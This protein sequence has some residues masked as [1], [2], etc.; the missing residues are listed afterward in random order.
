MRPD[1]AKLFT[2]NLWLKVISIFIAVVLWS[3][4]SSRE[5]ELEVP[6][7]V[8][9]EIKNLSK[10]LVR[11]SD[12]PNEIEIKARGPRTVLRSLRNREMRYVLDLSGAM[13][14]PMV[15]K[16][17]DSKIEG[18]PKGASVSEIYPSQIQLTLS[19]R[20]SRTVR[21][22]PVFRGTP[23]DGKEV[24]KPVVE[25][26][27]VEISGAT[28]EIETLTEVETE[29]IDLTG[30]AETFVV[31]V[32]LDLINRHVEPV[33][34]QSVRVTVPISEPRISKVFYGIPIEV[35]N[36]GYV[37]ELS[38]DDLDVQLEGPE[39]QLRLLTPGELL[40]V[41][42]AA[43]LAPGGEYEVAPTLVVSEGLG[44]RNFNMPNVK[45]KVLNKKKL[46]PA[47]SGKKKAK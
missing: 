25:P 8:S 40:L 23:A 43:E 45:I 5:T 34:D 9:L 27:L 18:L 37:F 35:R 42:D 3:I 2:E 1:W 30:H 29:I 26:E 17:Y 24:L 21:V 11:I 12:L 39:E 38:R 22:K 28:E 14:G 41:I 15:V 6:A 31:E 44:I 4:V 33:R 10:R 13:P 46:S 7:K 16:F 32:G 20:K 47:G 19:E 36:T